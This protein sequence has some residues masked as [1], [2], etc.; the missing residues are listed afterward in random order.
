VAEKTTG[1]G[2]GQAKRAKEGGYPHPLWSKNPSAP[3][4]NKWDGK[5]IS[6]SLSEADPK[7]VDKGDTSRILV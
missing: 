3:V 2:E 7:Q 4:G 5:P 1:A 6:A